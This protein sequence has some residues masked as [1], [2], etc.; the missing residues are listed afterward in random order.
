[1]KSKNGFGFDT[2]LL[3]EKINQD[4]FLNLRYCCCTVMKVAYTIADKI[5]GFLG[6]E[7]DTGTIL[8]KFENEKHKIAFYVKN[9][10]FTFDIC[11]GKDWVTGKNTNFLV[12]ENAKLQYENKFKNVESYD[13]IEDVLEMEEE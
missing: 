5:F 11:W 7:W 10:V 9:G 3:N 6:L 2:D 8:Y 13:Y 4:G 12:I 1:M